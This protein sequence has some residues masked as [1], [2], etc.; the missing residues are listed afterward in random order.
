ML[1]N[2]TLKGSSPDVGEITLTA[3]IE[4]ETMTGT[5]GVGPMGDAPFTG[6]RD[7]GD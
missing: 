2:W 7:T 6:K 1:G 3:S 4:G 5:L